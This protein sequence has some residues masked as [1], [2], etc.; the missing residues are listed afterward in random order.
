MVNLNEIV[1]KRPRSLMKARCTREVLEGRK[2]VLCASH[3]KSGIRIEGI[4]QRGCGV[5]LIKSARGLSAIWEEILGR[6]R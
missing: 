5:G 4:L 3:H 6:P 1:G 2:G